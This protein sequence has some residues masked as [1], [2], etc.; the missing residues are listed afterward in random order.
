VDLNGKHQ[1]LVN[2]EVINILS[3]NVS[4]IKKTQK[5]CQRLVGRL[6]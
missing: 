1:I 2:A 3:E 4:I 6:V 5:L